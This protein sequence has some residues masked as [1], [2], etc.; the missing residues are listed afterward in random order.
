[1]GEAADKQMALLEAILKRHD[2][3]VEHAFKAE[4]DTE[5]KEIVEE[6]VQN[7]MAAS[8][9]V[10]PQQ[11]LMVGVKYCLLALQEW[12]LKGPEGDS[13]TPVY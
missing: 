6:G 10:A 12:R 1:M 4:G 3:A 7:F 2:A 9:G 13:Q 8:A 11:R 5:S